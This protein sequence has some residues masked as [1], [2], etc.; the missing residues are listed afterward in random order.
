MFRLMRFS[1]RAEEFIGV[2][3]FV[4]PRGVSLLGE[5]KEVRV[6]AADL[7]FFTGVVCVVRVGAGVKV[8]VSMLSSIGRGD[9]RMELGSISSDFR[10]LL[11][12]VDMWL[13]K[14]QR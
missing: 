12:L 11:E 1:G 2:D 10:D 7:P 6:L 4:F 3:L 8:S 13:V 9:L 5:K 14:N